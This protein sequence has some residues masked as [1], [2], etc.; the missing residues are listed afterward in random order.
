MIKT[1]FPFFT[2]SLLVVILYF[3]VLKELVYDW[4]VDP[5]YTHGFLIPFISGYFVWE[6][7]EKLGKLTV[8]PF[9]WAI[10]LLIFGI[11]ILFIGHIGAELFTM[12]FSLIIVIAGLILFLLGKD[13]FKT[14][15]FPI[16]FLVFMVPLPYLVYDSIAFPLKLFAARCA[17]LSLQLMGIPVLREGNI[18]TLAS[19]TLEVADA[20]SGI[21]SL[22]SLIALGMVYAY[23]SQTVTWKRVTVVLLTIP[24]A[25][26]VN[27]FRLVV[28]GALAHYIDPEL[29]HGFFHTF[30]GWIIFLLAFLLLLATGS[31]LGRIFPEE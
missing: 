18:I 8:K 21:R 19:T 3:P 23:F 10:L 9:N 14:L 26:F 25:I 6:K 2:I 24:I 20:C 1:A 12:R 28:T 15:F 16:S 7:R 30:S 31:I 5:N 27:A 22:I 13:F 11:F 4:Y 29:A 17:A